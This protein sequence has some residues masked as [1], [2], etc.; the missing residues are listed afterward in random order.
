MRA[1][2]T[3]LVT[4]WC[5][6]A[7]A[8]NPECLAVLKKAGEGGLILD[9]KATPQ[10]M[11]FVVNEGLW[12]GIAF[13]SKEGLIKN[14]NCGLLDEGKVFNPIIFR[15]HLTNKIIGRQDMGKLTIPD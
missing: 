14:I 15:S 8:A 5:G 10:G 12:S 4:L 3:I 2:I 11:E 9:M 7:F 1:I 13:R 6:F